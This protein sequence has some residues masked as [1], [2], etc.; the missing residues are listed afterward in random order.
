L[1]TTRKIIRMRWLYILL[2]GYSPV[3][4]DSM[5]LTCKLA[6][7]NITSNVT[8][9]SIR[10]SCFGYQNLGELYPDYSSVTNFKSSID[11]MV[12]DEKLLAHK[13]LYTPVRPKF[14][15]DPKHI[16]YIELRFV[17]INPLYKA[18][19]TKEALQF[20]HAL[21]IYG[22]LSEEPG[23]FDVAA[24]AKAN[25]YHGMVALYALNSKTSLFEING[26]PIDLWAEGAAHIHNII[27]LFDKLEINDE[28]YRT[29]L[30]QVKELV[31]DPAKR[32]VFKILE[33]VNQLGYIPW[34]MKLAH[35]Y[36]EESKLKDYSFKG[37]KD[38]E[39]STQLL[40]REAVRRGVA[41]E[42][43]DRKEN[44]IRLEKDGNIQYVKQATKTS[45]D[46]YATILAMEN[47]LV[48]KKILG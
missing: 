41:F 23:D 4:D 44:F 9:L 6:P 48:T 32:E 40:L 7:H 39:L 17:D 3:V 38:M 24:Q 26:K 19:I 15:K 14:I 30:L 35:E 21:A 33:G 18:G 5:E 47:K 12:K 36:L 37:L 16:T 43:M 1:K 25:K 45:L 46:N 28:G 27:S 11:E 22:L 31:E 20:L 8:G 29:A 10:N 42:L 34:H 2:Y 13:E